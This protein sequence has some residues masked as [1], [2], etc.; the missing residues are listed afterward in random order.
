MNDLKNLLLENGFVQTNKNE[1]NIE[2]LYKTDGITIKKEADL[3]YTSAERK[4]EP[5][6]MFL[7]E[8]NNGNWD[9]NTPYCIVDDDLKKKLIE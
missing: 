3:F 5:L 7:R 4:N 1:P 8:C 6:V 9:K 2:R